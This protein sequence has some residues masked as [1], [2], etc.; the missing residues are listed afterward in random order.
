MNLPGIDFITIF[1]ILDTNFCLA[2]YYKN[3]KSL[4]KSNSGGVIFCT[5]GT[6]YAVLYSQKYT[7]LHRFSIHALLL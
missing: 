6:Q 5:I 3:E 7:L 1:T 4:I 2:L